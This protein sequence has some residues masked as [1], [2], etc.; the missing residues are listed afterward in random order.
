MTALINGIY[1]RTRL[2]STRTKL[3]ISL[4]ATQLLVLIVALAAYASLSGR[5]PLNLLAIDPRVLIVAIIALIL[6]ISGTTLILEMM[7]F[8]RLSLLS[9]SLEHQATSG[10]PYVAM[11]ELD[12]DEFGRLI[13]AL[14]SM[15]TLYR[16]SFHTLAHRA[17]ELA[18]LNRV[19]ETINRTL[20]LQEVFDVSLRG[21]LR[22]VD[23][24][25]GAIYMWD[26]R[27]ETLN[28]VTYEGIRDDIVRDIIV[29][30]LGEGITGEAAMARKMIIVEDTRNYP[31]AAI[32]YRE[33]MPI[34]Q[35]S[36]PL[37][38]VAGQMVGVLN[39]SAST[40][41]ALTSDQLNLLMTVAHQ[42]AVAIDKAQ[43]YSK[44]NRHA[45]ELERIVE[46]RTKQLAQVI[47]E[48]VVAVER[49]KETDKVKSLLLSTVSHELRTPLATIK[50]ATSMLRAHHHQIAPE[51]LDEHL[52][53][54]EEESDKLTELIS[55]L[56]EMSRIEAGILQIHQQAIDLADVVQSAVE[57]AQLRLRDNQIT[58]TIS[59]PLP[60]CFGDARRI[61][62]IV[63]NLLDN[64]AKYSEPKRPILVRVEPRA[65]D[66]VVSVIDKGRGIAP[67]Q[68][69][70]IFDRFYQIEHGGD[71][72]R[73]GI[74]LGLAICRGLV[75]AHGGGIWVES[76]HG[77]GSTFSFSLPIAHTESIAEERWHETD[78]HPDR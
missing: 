56:L 31:D 19:A 52:A 53:D 67:E 5:A 16:R 4:G 76:E 30:K 37:L 40:K 39:V 62:Q 48:L 68:L 7:V 73:H 8:R 33:G 70:R 66:L 38:T 75:E 77:N 29:Y 59:A 65:S 61:E 26:E 55:S 28:M 44:V 32:R 17:D 54:I 71:S 10:D 78:Y 15:S 41:Q 45:V 60:P 72:G 22:A 14:N 1:S 69:E 25:T 58:V 20:D 35:I 50:G 27:D 43:L 51:L 36:I 42:V 9:S 6:S 63:A 11:E 13:S 34:S 12:G 21:A 23:W 2:W 74:G 24:D 46:A 49:A 18:T 64:A 57:R 3:W 47:D